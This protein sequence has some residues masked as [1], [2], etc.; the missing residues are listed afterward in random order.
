MKFNVKIVR[1]SETGVTWAVRLVTKGEVFGSNSHITH[2]EDEPFVEF[3][4]TR[5]SHTDLGQFVSRYNLSTLLEHKGGL[6]LDTGSPDWYVSART[7]THVHN[8]LL[9]ETDT[10][11][12]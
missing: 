4:D 8:W 5:H 7:M 6:L 2:K 11:P 10:F 3:F 9:F 1:D 12:A